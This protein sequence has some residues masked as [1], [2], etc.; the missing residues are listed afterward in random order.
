MHGVDLKA[1]RVA[2]CV[3]T[4]LR[5][6]LTLSNPTEALALAGDLQN[7]KKRGNA[8]HNISEHTE[9]DKGKTS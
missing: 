6:R 8:E 7:K 9:Q 2:R 4:R 3:L 1:G 5:H